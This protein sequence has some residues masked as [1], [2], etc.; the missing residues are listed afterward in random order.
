LFQFL[1]LAARFVRAF[2]GSAG[3]PVVTM[4]CLGGIYALFSVHRLS[5]Q[6]FPLLFGVHRYDS[7]IA[8]LA[9]Q[10]FEYFFRAINS[11]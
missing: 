5:F 8:F 1:D 7:L 4:D 2:A 6:A 9:F 3:T 11:L 10:H